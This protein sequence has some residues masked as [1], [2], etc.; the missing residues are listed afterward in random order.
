PLCQ[1]VRKGCCMFLLRLGGFIGRYPCWFL[2][3]PLFLAGGLGSGFIFLREREA[4]GIEDQFTPVNG[5][6]KLERAFIQE[7]FTNDSDFSQLRLTSEGTYASV[8]ITG[9]QQKNILTVDAFTEILDLD[10]EVKNVNTGDTFVSLCAQTAGKCMSNAVLD[11]INFTA[12][13]IQSTKI[14]YPVCK[15]KLSVCVLLYNFEYLCCSCS[16]SYIR[17]R[18]QL[19]NCLVLVYNLKL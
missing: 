19:S 8:I 15:K 2:F 12:S 9:L 6:A 11:F 18:F 17:R 16:P 10:N 3:L 13:K 7:H 1:V 5:P 4:N 14:K